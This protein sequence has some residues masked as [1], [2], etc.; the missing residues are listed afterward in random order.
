MRENKDTETC[1]C[2]LKGSSG[3][4]VWAFLKD[5]SRMQKPRLKAAQ[6]RGMA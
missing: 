6:V 2:K 4:V 3:N 1:G 5:E